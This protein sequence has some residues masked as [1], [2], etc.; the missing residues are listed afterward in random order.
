MRTLRA[1]VANYLPYYVPRVLYTICACIEHCE[2]CGARGE[3]PN[4]LALIGALFPFVTIDFV[5]TGNK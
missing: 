1:T 2:G 4:L 3:V 5:P